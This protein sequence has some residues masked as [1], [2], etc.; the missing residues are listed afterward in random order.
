MSARKEEEITFDENLLRCVDIDRLHTLLKETGHSVP[1]RIDE[2]VLGML[3]ITAAKYKRLAPKEAAPKR[4]SEMS[5]ALR[6]VL[7]GDSFSDEVFMHR[8]FIIPDDKVGFIR[9]WHE[10]IYAPTSAT[11]WEDKTSM[12]SLIEDTLINGSVIPLAD[13]EQRIPRTI[14]YRRG[15]YA[16]TIFNFVSP[17]TVT[18]GSSSKAVRRTSQRIGVSTEAL[19]AALLLLKKGGSEVIHAMYQPRTFLALATD[20][21]IVMFTKWTKA[22]G[23]LPF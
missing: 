3:K 16:F 8:W 23:P 20:T 14:R 4:L 22:L 19:S 12:G 11:A 2:D 15:T 9:G 5:K 7:S 17:D 18:L 1:P 6:P 21:A 13:I 10:S